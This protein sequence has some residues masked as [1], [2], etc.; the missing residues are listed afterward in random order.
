MADRDALAA[1]AV[2]WVEPVTDADRWRWDAM[3]AQ[4]RVSELERRVAALEALVVAHAN[5]LV[6][7]LERIEGAGE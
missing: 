1:P 3:R 2:V 7:G 4:Q 6:D 5:D